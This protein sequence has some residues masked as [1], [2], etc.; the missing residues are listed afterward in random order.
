MT[1]YITLKELFFLLQVHVHTALMF[2]LHYSLLCIRVV[3]QCYVLA[4]VNTVYNTL[5]GLA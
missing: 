3:P 4:C 1:G 5:S 2:D